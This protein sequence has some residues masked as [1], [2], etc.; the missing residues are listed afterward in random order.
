M[1]AVHHWYYRYPSNL[2]RAY[3]SMLG[4]CWLIIVLIVGMGKLSEIRARNR[5]TAGSDTTSVIPITTIRYS[6]MAPPPSLSGS[7]VEA[8]ASLPDVAPAQIEDVTS[9]VPLPVPDE[10]AEAA[11]MATTKTIAGVAAPAATGT[12]PVVIL[13]ET[14]K[15]ENYDDNK[16]API[17]FKY[18]KS[19]IKPEPIKLVQPDYPE[20][21]RRLNIEGTATLYLWLRKDGTVATVSIFKTSGNALLDTAAA[22]AALK[23]TFT[24]AKGADGNPV[25]VWVSVPFRFSLT[26]S[27]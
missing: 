15:R 4:L 8:E 9:S 21:A 24:P 22:K 19:A 3:Y 18:T 12:G 23:S 16:P 13:P 10:L 1:L 5:G 20:N 6:E 25:N 14:T 17:A 27:K 2:R 7:R 11:T 26:G